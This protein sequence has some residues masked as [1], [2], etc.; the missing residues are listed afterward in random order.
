MVAVDGV[1]EGMM[2]PV[3]AYMWWEKDDVG[4]VIGVGVPAVARVW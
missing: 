4:N 2:D 3:C 1:I